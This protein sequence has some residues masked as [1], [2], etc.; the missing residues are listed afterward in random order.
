MSVSTAPASGEPTCSTAPP[1]HL[2]APPRPIGRKRH[3][4]ALGCTLALLALTV[5]CSSGSDRSGNAGNGARVPAP[6]FAGP[7]LVSSTVVDGAGASSGG[8]VETMSLARFDGST[9]TLADYRG[10]PLVV[11]FFAS[12][13]APCVREMSDFEQV[14]RDLSRRVAFLGVNVRDRVDDGRSIVARTGVSYDVARD[15]RGDLLQRLGGAAMPTTALFDAQGRLILLQSRTY[16][17]AGLRSAIEKKLL[18]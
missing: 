15:P 7:G 18:A 12:W 13:C 17:A 6:S 3:A 4:A 1:G 5:A 2:P 14:H 9:A 16:D 8:A 10:R 11:N